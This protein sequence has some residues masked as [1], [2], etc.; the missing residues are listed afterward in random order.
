MFDWRYSLVGADTNSNRD[1]YTLA[2]GST[3]VLQSRSDA[4]VVGNQ[5]SHKMACFVGDGGFVDF[6]SNSTNL[7]PATAPSTAAVFRVPYPRN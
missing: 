7:G 1:I 2:F 4:G 3:P 6:L 5:T